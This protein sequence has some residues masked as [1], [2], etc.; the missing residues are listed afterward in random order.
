MLFDN[1]KKM[2]IKFAIKVYFNCL[3][4]DFFKYVLKASKITQDV[5]NFAS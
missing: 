3:Y 4:T 1:W 5:I 2:L